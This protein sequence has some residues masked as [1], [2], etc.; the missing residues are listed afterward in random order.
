MFGAAA[1]AFGADDGFE[2]RTVPHV[3]PGDE[4]APGVESVTAWLVAPETGRA[5]LGVEHVVDASGSMVW[6]EEIGP[7]DS[8]GSP[9]WSTIV[10]VVRLPTRPDLV[11]VGFDCVVGDGP[12]R[13]DLVVLAGDEGVRPERAW[14]VDLDARRLV[15]MSAAGVSCP[16]QFED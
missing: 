7:R 14:T 4:V 2:G 1:A 10:D 6:L 3:V 15:E 13:R 8:L 16:V 5:T 12:P 9:R 11:V